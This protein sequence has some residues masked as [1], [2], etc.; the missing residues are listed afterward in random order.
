MPLEKV[1]LELTSSCN[2]NCS[3]CYRKTWKNKTNDMDQDI[4]DK[5]IKE[6]NDSKTIKEVVLGGIGEPTYAKESEKIMYKLKGK[7]LTLTTNG[8]ILHE[9]MR[10]AIVDTVDHIV[11]SIDGLYETF[12]NIRNFSLEKIVE[13]IKEINN[14]KN[15]IRSKSPLIS[16]QT[17]ISRENKD[18]IIGII[19][20]AA[21]INVSNIIISNLQPTSF[22]D[23]DLILYK[24]YENTELRDFY[25]SISNYAL[26]KGIMLK[27]PEYELKTERRCRFIENNTTMV[28]STGDIVP[29]YRLGH[30]GKEVVFG[31][32]KEIKAHSFGNIRISTMQE[33]WESESYIR[34]RSTIY[35]N[36]YPSCI[37]CDLV[38]G[39]DLVNNTQGDCYGNE[40][41]CSDCLWTRNFIFCV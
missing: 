22:A 20:L 29:C 8:T 10:K 31:R 16:F 1:Y 39:C 41:A 2:L 13:N 37:D 27:L 40:P 3:M 21:S 25:Y 33:I 11:I 15:K 19:D 38:E 17:V 28:S 9:S 12:Y 35:N 23:K 24:R 18:E 34:F 7:Y 26:R 36:H 6:I 32:E 14:L 4:L 5:C 30:D